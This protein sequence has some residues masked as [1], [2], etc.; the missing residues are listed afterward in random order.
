MKEIRRQ[1][2]LSLLVTL[3][4]T[5]LLVQILIQPWLGVERRRGFIR[6]W[7]RLLM[8][9]CGVKVVERV[10]AP[11]SVVGSVE[12]ETA[13]TAGLVR[14]TASSQTAEAAVHTTSAVPPASAGR[15]EDHTK[16]ASLTELAR[17]RMLVA[18]HPSWLDIFAIDALAPA[19]FVA[20]AEIE[21]WPLVGQLVAQAGTVFIQRGNRR[22]VPE[23]IQQMRERLRQGWPVAFF[24]E[25]GTNA[26]PTLLPFHSNLLE[27]AIA[28]SA[29]VVPI[30][31][32]YRHPDGSVGEEAH[33]L[34]ETTFFQSVW[35]IL[36]ARRLIVTL[37]VLPPVPTAGRRRQE[38]GI[39]LRRQI[40][41][42]LGMDGQDSQP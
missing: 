23:A 17:G 5:G 1:F 8:A 28:E 24:P 37:H 36:G 38:L 6:V 34:G 11:T 25:A 14:M 41:E 39:E 15:T 35:T 27:A 26:G 31:I 20:K 7:S 33:F 3:L 4:V 30:A 10:A 22:A 2:R 19:S 32:D 21:R 29:E 9:A 40:G 42:A 16:A 12:P 13:T 18:N